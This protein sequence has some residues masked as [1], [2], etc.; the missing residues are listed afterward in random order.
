MNLFK[1]KQKQMYDNEHLPQP[2]GTRKK[3]PWSRRRDAG[4][5]AE[6]SPSNVKGKNQEEDKQQPTQPPRANASEGQGPTSLWD[7]AYDSLKDK[8]KTLVT[9]YEELLS[10]ELAPDVN[11]PGL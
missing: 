11:T 8:N 4:L 5:Q 1:Q 3:W 6:S 10:K 9:E 7:R 2:Q